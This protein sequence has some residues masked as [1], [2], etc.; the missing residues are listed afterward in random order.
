MIRYS[1]TH[2]LG[3]LIDRTLV[4]RA[5]RKACV[6]PRGLENK[7]AILS[8]CDFA[9]DGDFSLVVHSVKRI[10]PFVFGGLINFRSSVTVI[11]V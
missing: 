10:F 1:G 3:F 11:A 9:R 4:V 8:Y 7:E 5:V 6:P 2:G